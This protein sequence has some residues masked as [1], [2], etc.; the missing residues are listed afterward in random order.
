[1]RWVLPLVMSLV[2]LSSSRGR[3]E[4]STMTAVPDP[5]M[6]SSAEAAPDRQPQAASAP[7]GESYQRPT[8]GD[9]GRVRPAWYGWQ[10][11]LA[12]LSTVGAALGTQSG[13]LGVSGYFALP[14]MV[15]LGNGE[16]ARAAG[17]VGL[18][19]ALPVLLA[20]GMSSGK[21]DG[22]DDF[23]TGLWAG[24]VLASALDVAVLAWSRPS[25][26]EPPGAED[27]ERSREPERKP[28][29]EPRIQPLPRGMSAGIVGG[30]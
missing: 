2:L 6:D 12:D 8:S 17:S 30:F 22:F 5:D 3:A 13:E 20:N 26:P 1:M 14:P 27:G 9:L 28:W 10:I 23:V 25:P 4:T 29:F 21:S 15:H 18:R 7:R 24:A 19:L 16:A 11:I